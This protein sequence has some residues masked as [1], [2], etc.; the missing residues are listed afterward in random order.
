M[1][2]KFHPR[3]WERVACGADAE[4]VPCDCCGEDLRG[5]T[6]LESAGYA[7]NA[8]GQ[9]CAETIEQ[10]QVFARDVA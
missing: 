8:C 4:P 1:A 2:T 7:S 6:H 5:R 3:R 10:A 9:P